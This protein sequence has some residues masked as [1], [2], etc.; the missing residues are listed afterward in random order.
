MSSSSTVKIETYDSK[1]KFAM[2]LPVNYVCGC[3]VD[4]HVISSYADYLGRRQLR[5]IIMNGKLK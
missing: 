3:D 1:T 4:C 5:R 2:R